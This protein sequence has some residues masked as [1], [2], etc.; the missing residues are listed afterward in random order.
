MAASLTLAVLVSGRGSNL[1]ALL[2]AIDRGACAATVGCVISDRPG[3]PAL[4]LA[5]ARGIATHVVPA[6]AY[7]DRAAWDEALASQLAAA[8]PELIV[9]AGFMRIVGRAVLAH[10]AGRIINVHPALLPAFPGMDA[11]AQAIAARVCL[12]GCTVH[13]VDDGVDTGPVLA[14]AAVPV[15]RDDDADSLHARI[16]TAEHA[17]LPAVVHAIATGALVLEREAPRYTGSYPEELPRLVSP[18]LL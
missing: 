12:S 2:E 7:A 9:L 1:K 15:R 11:P 14:Q 17:L 16:Q 3:A 4:S 18:P 8:A 6:K 10:F 5:S 13:V